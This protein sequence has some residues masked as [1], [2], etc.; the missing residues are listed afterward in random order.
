[1]FFCLNIYDNGDLFL[2]HFDT[3]TRWN[4]DTLKRWHVDTLTRWHIDTL[5]RCHVVTLT[6]WYVDTLTRWY[7]DALTWW[8][9][10]MLALSQKRLQASK[11]FLNLKFISNSWLFKCCFD[12]TRWR[13][14][15][16][17]LIACFFG[18]DNFWS[19]ISLGQQKCLE[20]FGFTQVWTIIK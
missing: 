12:R 8:H 7:V 14:F 4:V 2:W 1:M 15:I 16:Q 13:S 18:S 19:L 9:G 20:K 10:D 17:T 3:L 5:T 6:R 11:A